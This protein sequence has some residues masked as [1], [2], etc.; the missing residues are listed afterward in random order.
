MTW[1]DKAQGWHVLLLIRVQVFTSNL[2]I[3]TYSTNYASSI[4]TFFRVLNKFVSYRNKNKSYWFLKYESFFI[5]MFMSP[6][7]NAVCLRSFSTVECNA[8]KKIQSLLFLQE[9]G[10]LKFWQLI[11]FLFL[12]SKILCQ[13]HNVLWR[14]TS[15]YLA[16]YLLYNKGR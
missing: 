4:V 15:I 1:L 13:K 7:I 14:K 2:Q 9:T 10:L 3:F 8:I 12:Q 11:F 16:L 5:F 6:K